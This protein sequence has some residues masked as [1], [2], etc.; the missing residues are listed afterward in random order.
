M[1]V[2]GKSI[3]KLPNLG[4]KLLQYLH[5]HVGQLCSYEDI[6]RGVWTDSEDDIKDGGWM[7]EYGRQK[8]NARIVDLRKRLEPVPKDPKYI[9]LIHDQG[10]KLEL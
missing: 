3:D 7:L 5:N 8:V 2:E 4:W 6:L 1:T 10:Y 9:L